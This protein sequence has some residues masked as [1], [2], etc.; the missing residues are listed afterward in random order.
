MP[1]RY[2]SYYNRRL[3][4]ANRGRQRSARF[5]GYRRKY[6]TAYPRFNRAVLPLARARGAGLNGRMYRWTARQKR[7]SRRMYARS[8]ALTAKQRGIE[9]LTYKN[10]QTFLLDA[11]SMVN[12]ADESKGRQAFNLTMN[13]IMTPDNILYVKNNFKTFTI[14]K[15]VLRV[16][17]LEV[18]LP[19]YRGIGP[20]AP[21]V[22]TAVMPMPSK[23]TPNLCAMITNF[24]DSPV[25]VGGSGA[26]ETLDL[27]MDSVATQWRDHPKVKKVGETR[28]TAFYW[29]APKYAQ[30]RKHSTVP[31]DSA[32]TERIYEFLDHVDQ[33]QQLDRLYFFWKDLLRFAHD[34]LANHTTLKMAIQGT[35]LLKAT[36]STKWLSTG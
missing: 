12:L 19:Y 6:S 24:L 5:S 18:K 9:I 2:G 25:P 8:S 11:H 27:S 32:G 22:N 31:L 10:T 21:Y 26:N 20:V 34:D 36:D 17:L 16:Q 35:V 15:I 4:L 14:L 1:R 30:G 29:T 28:P 13:N 23:L 3:R 33:N 7:Q